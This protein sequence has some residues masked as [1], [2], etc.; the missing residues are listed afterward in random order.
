M[1]PFTDGALNSRPVSAWT[2]LLSLSF[3]F[4]FIFL[5]HGGFI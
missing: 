4:P 1:Y 5:Y 3:L 2:L